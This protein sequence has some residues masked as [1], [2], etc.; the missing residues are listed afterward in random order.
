[1]RYILTNDLENRIT[2][3]ISYTYNEQGLL[4]SQKIIDKNKSL[5]KEYLYDKYSNMIK[6]TITGDD[7]EDN[8]TEYT[9]DLDGINLI[10]IRNTHLIDQTITNTYDKKNNIITTTDLNHLTT[11]FEYD[12][13]NRQTK[14]TRPNGTT[15]TWEYNWNNTYTNSLYTITIKNTGEPKV[16]TYFDKKDRKIRVQKVGFKGNK[17]FEDTFYDDQGRLIK[18]TAPYFD[19]ELPN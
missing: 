9:Y 6:E 5:K 17:I 3:Q 14:A 11:S 15:T 13:L 19:E 12:K 7:I 4:L 1:M 16:T 10:E 8:S 18:R 2:N